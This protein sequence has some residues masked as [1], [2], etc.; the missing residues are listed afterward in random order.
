MTGL[1]TT[2]RAAR[3]WEGGGEKFCAIPQ[4]Q[5]SQITLI[6]GRGLETGLGITVWALRP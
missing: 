3:C 5:W 4:G 2:E 1:G 6:E